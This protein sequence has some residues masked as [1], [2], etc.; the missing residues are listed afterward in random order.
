[1]QELISPRQFFFFNLTWAKIGTKSSFYSLITKVTG[2]DKRSLLDRDLSLVSIALRMSCASKRQT[3]RLE[4][5]ACCLLG[6][7]DVHMPLLYGEEKG[8]SSGFK[9]RL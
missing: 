9:K 5:L 1:L 8:L 7:F 2:I 6:I 3:T 4:D